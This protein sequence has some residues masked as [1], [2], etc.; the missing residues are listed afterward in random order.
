M[1]RLAP[2]GAWEYL[3]MALEWSPDGKAG[4]WLEQKIRGFGENVGSVVPTGFERYVRVFHPITTGPDRRWSG[5]AARHGRVAHAEMQFHLISNPPG[6][7][8]A[9]YEPLEAM[10]VGTLPRSE[11]HVIAAILERHTST[12]NRCHFAI[13][14]GFGI[15]PLATPPV[16][17]L[18]RLHLPNRAYVLMHGTVADASDAFDRLEEQSANLWWPDDHAWCVAS[19]IDFGWTYVGG[20]R[21]AISELL[22]APEIEA[23]EARVTDGVRYDSDHVNAALDADAMAASTRQPVQS[24]ASSGARTKRRWWRRERWTSTKQ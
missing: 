19:E 22:A 16:P 14:E 1:A 5:L 18:A 21:I 6:S 11:L 23:M 2:A 13:W 9:G 24:D 3:R 10:A 7:A 12:P 20:S 15:R 17:D 8:P 4:T